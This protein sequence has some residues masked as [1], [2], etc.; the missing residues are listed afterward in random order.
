M[1]R[2]ALIGCGGHAAAGHA[3]PLRRYATQYPERVQLIACCDVRLERA[4]EFC[5]R[6]GFATPYSDW[7]KM[8]DTERPDT[9]VCAVP[10]D[11]TVPIGTEIL[12]RGL[13]CVLEK[14]PGSTLQEVATLATVALETNTP[15]L[16]SVNRRFNPFL[17]KALAW[18][19]EVGPLQ[20]VHSRM[21]RHNRREPE[22]PWGTGVHIVDAMRHIGGEWQTLTVR[23]VTPAQTSTP[24]F[25]VSLR[26]ETGCIGTVEIAPTVGMVEETYELYGE[27]FRASVTTLGGMG[28]GV[29]FWRDGKLER[30]EF[31][32]PDAPAYL[33]DGSYEE[34]VTF[35]DAIRQ[36]TP[37]RPTVGDVAP[38]MDLCA[39]ICAALGVEGP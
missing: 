30:A 8:L 27:G 28:E 29:R 7:Q 18:A 2:L 26:F 15:H 39:Q 38:S 31:S 3:E 9:V 35:L 1:I 37:L 33:R 16:V 20:Y 22:F 36:G 23:T 21:L 5:Q 25:F 32:E 10:I 11:Q 17:N 34:T 4:E 14:P 19:K 12:R 13:P 24:W 6:Y